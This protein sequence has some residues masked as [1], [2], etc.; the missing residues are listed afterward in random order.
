MVVYPAC[1]KDCEGACDAHDIIV[2]D[3]TTVTSKLVSDPLGEAFD[4]VISEITACTL[5]VYV[6]FYYR[7]KNQ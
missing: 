4:F 1:S 6:D 2:L 5:S 7:R 3:T